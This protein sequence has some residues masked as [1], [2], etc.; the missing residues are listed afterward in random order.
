MPMTSAEVGHLGGRKWLLLG[1][2]VCLPGLPPPLAVAPSQV[3][4]LAAEGLTE[5]LEALSAHKPLSFSAPHHP[6][7]CPHLY[8]LPHPHLFKPPN[9]SSQS[10][11]SPLAMPPGGGVPVGGQLGT[12]SLPIRL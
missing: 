9:S 2:L 7:P 5:W 3:A 8:P 4:L 12:L 1:S 6:F 11:F 10:P